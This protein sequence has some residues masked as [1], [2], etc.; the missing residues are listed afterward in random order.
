MSMM[1]ALH[2]AK[3]NAKLYVIYIY[4]YI[5]N[6]IFSVKCFCPMLRGSCKVRPHVE[7][8]GRVFLAENS[9]LGCF[10]KPNK[11]T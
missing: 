1:L 3:R 8:V 11:G 7:S 4:I 2:L 10:S 5:A 6:V 9:Y